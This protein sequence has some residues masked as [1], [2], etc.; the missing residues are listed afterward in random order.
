MSRFF[1]RMISD[2]EKLKSPQVNLTIPTYGESGKKIDSCEM[3]SIAYGIHS[4]FGGNPSSEGFEAFWE[5]L[6]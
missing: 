6:W 4:G 2:P 3:I 1:L 5:V